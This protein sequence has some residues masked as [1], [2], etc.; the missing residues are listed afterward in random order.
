V[1]FDAALLGH[2]IAGA[3]SQLRD[4]IA[5]QLREK[6]RIGEG[7]FAGDRVQ[8]VMRTLLA[9]GCIGQEEVARAFGMNRRT[10]ARRLHEDG[11]TFRELLDTVRFDAARGLLRAS[12]V[13]LEDVADRL[14]Y[15]DVTAFARAFRRWSG[16]SPAVWRRKQVGVV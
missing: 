15:A 10:F 7:G 1:L 16:S 11:T 6:Q 8:R 3:N 9:T 2:P 5:S 14:G 12:A 4:F 13:S